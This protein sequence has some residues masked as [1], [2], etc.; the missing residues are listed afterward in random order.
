MIP[1]SE[2]EGKRLFKKQSIIEIVIETVVEKLKLLLCERVVQKSLRY[3]TIFA[4]CK[5]SGLWP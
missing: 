3:L 5:E 1:N 4:C 2:E